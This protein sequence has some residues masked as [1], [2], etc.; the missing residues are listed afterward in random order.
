M[1][2]GPLKNTPSKTTTHFLAPCANGA[3][4]TTTDCQRP[5][6]KVLCNRKEYIKILKEECPQTCGL[7]DSTIPSQDQDGDN[8]N[9][10]GDSDNEGGGDA[11]CVDND[12]NCPTFVE[13]GFCNLGFYSDETK[14]A[15]CGKSCGL[16]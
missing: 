10:G 6:V 8:D 12:P 2:P 7:C 15:T 14:K 16:C 13:N 5:D 4:D 1:I 9:G 11:S 3:V